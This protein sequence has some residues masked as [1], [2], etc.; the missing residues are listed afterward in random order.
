M[1][2]VSSRS[3]LAITLG[4]AVSLTTGCKDDGTGPEDI[5]AAVLSIASGNNQTGTV[6]QALA[7]LLAVR[8]ATSSGAPVAGVN[9][10]GASTSLRG[11]TPQ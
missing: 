6:G 5:V 8:V 4:L 9:V 1:R 11:S 10:S 3:A 2:P 7:N